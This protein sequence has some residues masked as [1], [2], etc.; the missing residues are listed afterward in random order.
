MLVGLDRPGLEV[1]RHV[2]FYKV[3]LL[4]ETEGLDLKSRT[5]E[6]I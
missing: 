6:W 1:G 5:S 3:G 2:T 4:L